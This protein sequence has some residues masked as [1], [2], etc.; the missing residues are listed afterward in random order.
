MD[1]KTKYLQVCFDLWRERKTLYSATSIMYV[2]L[3][4]QIP[5]SPIYYLCCVNLC[6]RR[7]HGYV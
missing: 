1:V 2:D 3:I 7:G 4:I 6:M 5:F